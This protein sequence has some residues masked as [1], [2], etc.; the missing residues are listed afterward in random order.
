[1]QLKTQK[2]QKKKKKKNS[3]KKKKKKKKNNLWASAATGDKMCGFWSKRGTESRYKWDKERGV[4]IAEYGIPRSFL[5]H[6]EVNNRLTGW[7]FPH[8]IKSFA[9]PVN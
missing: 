7:A 4:L 5:G 9:H 8:Q 1:M 3:K 6:M 2:T